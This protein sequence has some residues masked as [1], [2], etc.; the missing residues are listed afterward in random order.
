[1]RSTI[2]TTAIP[3][4]IQP[5]IWFKNEKALN[6]FVFTSSANAMTDAPITPHTPEMT[7]LLFST[8]D[9]SCRGISNA[10]N[11]AVTG[12]NFCAALLYY[13]CICNILSFSSANLTEIL[14]LSSALAS[15]CSFLI[16]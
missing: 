12:R 5:F 10:I 7:T 6:T 14:Y 2:T 16:F 13:Q 8:P 11:N 9:T 3:A 15:L 4:S 1:M